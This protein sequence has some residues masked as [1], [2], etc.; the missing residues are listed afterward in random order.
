MDHDELVKTLKDAMDPT[1]LTHYGRLGM[2]WGRHIFGDDRRSS[3][4]RA[5]K[6]R[7]KK[8]AKSAAVKT[9]RAQLKSMKR[10]GASS[11]AMRAVS[12]GQQHLRY[13]NDQ[14]MRDH[15]IR[16]GTMFHS[17]PDGDS[18]THYGRKGMKWYQHIF[19]SDRSGGTGRRASNALKGKYNRA[20]RARAAATAAKKARKAASRNYTDQ[21]R[22]REAMRTANKYKRGFMG[23]TKK[24]TVGARLRRSIVTRGTRKR[25]L[26]ELKSAKAD[27]KQTKRDYKLAKKGSKLADKELRNALKEWEAKQKKRKSKARHSMPEGD[28]LTHY[29]VKG[30]KWGYNKGRKN[31]KR[32]AGTEVSNLDEMNALRARNLTSRVRAELNKRDKWAAASK[33]S[34]AAQSKGRAELERR[35]RVREATAAAAARAKQRKT[36]KNNRKNA[37][38]KDAASIR[39]ARSASST[40]ARKKRNRQLNRIDGVK[41]GS[42]ATNRQIAMY[43]DRRNRKN[44]KNA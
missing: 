2:K 19:E 14:L 11:Q 7:K 6:T 4:T 39:S 36:S 31:G 21:R 17:M 18:L 42:K 34:S 35:R 24:R 30:S 38:S 15:M 26:Q 22:I 41:V 3:K 27:R 16:M 40:A 5:R 10:Q 32:T 25:Q 20:V 43:Y 28:S 13:M 12:A 33:A 8:A 23:R 44:L 37:N 29:G 9:V 1:T